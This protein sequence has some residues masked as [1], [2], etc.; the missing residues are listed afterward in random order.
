MCYT[1][2]TGS[3]IKRGT[4]LL[5]IRHIVQWTGLALALTLSTK[6]VSQDLPA[7]TQ[8]MNTWSMFNPAYTVA[9]QSLSGTLMYRNQWTGYEGAPVTQMAHL[10]YIIGG[11]HGVGL[12][13][14]HDQITVFKQTD[15][16]LNYGFKAKLD[17]HTYIGLGTSFSYHLEQNT[18]NEV[19]RIQDLD[20]RFMFASEGRQYVNFGFGAYFSAKQFYLGMSIPRMFRNKLNNFELETL[21]FKPFDADWYI[22]G[23]YDFDQSDDLVTSPIVKI[24]HKSGLPIQA[25]LGCQVLVNKQFWGYIGYNTK[26]ALSA[27][28]GYVL[29]DEF[30][31]SYSYELG[32]STTRAYGLGS[33][34]LTLN[35]G[36]PYYAD[37]FGKRMRLNRKAE[38]QD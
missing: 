35:Y 32:L 37:R 27:A 4:L 30:K 3:Q 12:T 5:S 8:Y 2:R 13:V 9:G 16:V 24:K 19:D 25:D 10:N 18:I 22:I 11:I 7:V 1:W 17:E 20:P 14:I 26:F 34:E 33:H 6:C 29:M 23:G 15:A 38:F 21:Q 31:A 36:I 28:I